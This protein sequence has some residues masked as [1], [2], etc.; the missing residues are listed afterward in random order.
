MR[1]RAILPPPS[2]C[3]ACTAAAACLTSEDEERDFWS[4]ISDMLLFFKIGFLLSK[5]ELDFV[6]STLLAGCDSVRLLLP[7]CSGPY[8]QVTSQSFG[9]AGRGRGARGM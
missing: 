8:S 7:V 9:R 2:F 3:C 5:N 6:S 4:I 1:G